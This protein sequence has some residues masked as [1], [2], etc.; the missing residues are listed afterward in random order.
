[1]SATVLA[2]STLAP[3]YAGVENGFFS[4]AGIDLALTQA[5]P[6]AV[7]PA[8][9]SG[10]TT[11]G[12]LAIPSILLAA[13]KDLPIKIVANAGASPDSP[14]V[15]P[16]ASAVQ[17]YADLA[18]KRIA[19]P[20]LGGLGQF[21]VVGALLNNG[22]DP[23]GVQLL[24]VPFGDMEAA[25]DRGTV[26]AAWLIQPFAALAEQHGKTRSL[27]SSVEAADMAAMGSAYFFTL[28]ET[29]T[30]NPDMVGR[31]VD[32]VKRSNAYGLENVDEMVDIVPS[33]AQIPPEVLG[34]K[35]VSATY[36]EIPVD[37]LKRVND[38]MVANGFLTKS[39]DVD[40]L[41]WTGAT[42]GR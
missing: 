35:L 7:V 4:E 16:N 41:V 2:A 15:V 27:G 39:V 21:A 36:G 37:Q 9:V 1:M 18:G 3:V 14:V 25:L 29:V 30:K 26:D 32:A 38:F 13:S 22:V 20:N 17:T 24:E 12:Y 33:F 23:A 10:S 11:F 5:A 42:A 31:F 28:D 40:A 19:V 8:V 34:P 6:S